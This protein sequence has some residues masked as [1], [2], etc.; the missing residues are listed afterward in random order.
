L[1]SRMTEFSPV[2]ITRFASTVLISAI[3]SSFFYHADPGTFSPVTVEGGIQT[4]G[5]H[6]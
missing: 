1:L 3:S 2:R 4:P 6:S 5:S